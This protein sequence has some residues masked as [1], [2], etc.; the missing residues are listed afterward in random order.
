MMD[1]FVST[2]CSLDEYAP[3]PFD[4]DYWFDE[5]PKCL[6]HKT[7]PY[8]DLHRRFK[9]RSRVTGKTADGWENHK[10][11]KV[12]EVFKKRN[13]AGHFGERRSMKKRAK[14]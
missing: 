6:A 13:T 10:E 4:D 5:V 14:F 2:P 12:M 11:L 7:V 8:T 9:E 3:E 1:A